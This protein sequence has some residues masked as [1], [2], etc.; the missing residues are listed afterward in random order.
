MQKV[1]ITYLNGSKSTEPVIYNISE[2]TL[3]TF[4]KCESST[5]VL[6]KNN[7]SFATNHCSIIY[8]ANSFYLRDDA[9][10]RKKSTLINGNRHEL[11]EKLFVGDRIRLGLKNN[12]EFTI[13]FNPRPA[14]S[15]K[16]SSDVKVDDKISWT[17][18]VIKYVL[19]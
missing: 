2:A 17:K 19:G 4:G 11:S 12:I 9:P 13:D 18:N 3:I 8:Q 10:R 1:I 5:V 7:D 6:D 16:T 15:Y 14:S